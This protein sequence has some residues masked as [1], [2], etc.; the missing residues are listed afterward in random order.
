MLVEPK[1]EDLLPKAENRYTLAILVA[2]RTRQL[3]D[4]ARP[5]VDSDSPNLVT[6]AC[7]ELAQDRVRGIKGIRNVYIPLRPEIEAARLA[8]RTAA[9]QT[10]LADAIREQVDAAADELVGVEEPD[11]DLFATRFSENAARLSDTNLDNA[12]EQAMGEMIEQHSRA[13]EVTND[14]LDAGEPL[15]FGTPDVTVDEMAEDFEDNARAVAYADDALVSFRRKAEAREQ[16]GDATGEGADSAA[17]AG[18]D[19]EEA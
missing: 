4:G 8:A 13:D 3:V 12:R 16:G 7:E 10:S 2:K 14:Q 6:L 9:E 19:A 18:D 1:M 15:V 5:L 17:N 11:A